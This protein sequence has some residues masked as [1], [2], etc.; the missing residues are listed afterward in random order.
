MRQR[1][2]T[3]DPGNLWE[4]VVLSMIISETLDCRDALLL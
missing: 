3:S 2:E 1:E 4:T